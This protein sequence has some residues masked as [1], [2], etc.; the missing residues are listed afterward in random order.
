MSSVDLNRPERKVY[1][2]CFLKT[3]L[4]QNETLMIRFVDFELIK[5]K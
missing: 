2:Y 4:M 5:Q 3:W 1:L